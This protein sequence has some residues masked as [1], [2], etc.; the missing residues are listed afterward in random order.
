MKITTIQLSDEMKKKLSSFG[1]KGESYEQ[2]LKRIYD[3]AVKVQLREFLMS[4][5]GCIPIEQAIKEAEEKW[6][7]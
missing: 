4:E 7:E 2:I 5:E 3:V 1:N 6:S